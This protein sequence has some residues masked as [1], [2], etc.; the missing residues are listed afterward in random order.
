MSNEKVIA[1]YVVVGFYPK[2][3]RWSLV[4]LGGK[5]K[6]DA[7]KALEDVKANPK[8]YGINRTNADEVT[9]FALEPIYEKEEKTAWWNW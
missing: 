6:A 8:K 4:C 9:E 5:D 1:R 7:E 2:N 3:N